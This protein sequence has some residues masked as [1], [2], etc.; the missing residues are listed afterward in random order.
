MLVSGAL[1]SGVLV[2]GG[3]VV[4]APYVG[5]ALM[6]FPFLLPFTGGGAEAGAVGSEPF[7]AVEPGTTG[8]GV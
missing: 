1:V 5:R 6:P 4:V 7:Q 3:G 8:F 2:S